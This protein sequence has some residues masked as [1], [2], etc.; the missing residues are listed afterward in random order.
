MTDW[1]KLKVVD[2]KAELKNRSLP[3]H[4]LKTELVARLEEAEQDTADGQDDA[5]SG[6]DVQ[7]TPDH[8]G[9]EDIEAPANGTGTA[10]TEPVEATELNTEETAEGNLQKENN[11]EE[12]TIVKPTEAA[13]DEA[14]SQEETSKS[15][16]TDEPV[17]PIPPEDAPT[18]D[19]ETEPQPTQ[20]AV[21]TSTE[22]QE[23]K[24][25]NALIEPTPTYSLEATPAAERQKRKRR[26]V[27]PPPTQG[28]IEHKRAR[29]ESDTEKG[30]PVVEPGSSNEEL[31]P[32]TEEQPE[33]MNIDQDPPAKDSRDSPVPLVESGSRPSPTAEMEDDMDYE[34]AVAPSVHTATP[35]LY[36]KNFMRPLRPD[37]VKTHLAG[38]AHSPRERTDESI[39]VDFFL[40]PIR[41]HAFVVFK[42]TTAASRVRTALHDSVW[43]NESNRKPL[44]VD[45]VPPEKV[46]GWIDTEMESGG[47]RGRSGSRWEVI[48]EDGPSGSVEAHLESG[49]ASFPRAG[50]PPSNRPPLGPSL[51][52]NDSIPLGPRGLRNQAIPTGPRPVRPG[53]GP[54]PRPP[55]SNPLGSS[56]R[57]Q[58]RPQI[59]YQP[60]TPDLAQTRIENMRSFYST[61]RHRDLGREI[62]RYSFESG[63]HFV[64]RGKE[65]FEGIRPPHR[66]RDRRGGGR[67]GRGGFRP[68]GDRYQPSRLD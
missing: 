39:I 47:P 13:N 19:R 67:R 55:P 52:S 30:A 38:L 24:D 35:A 59:H 1:A 12:E 40:D 63:V 41:T 44:W 17:H 66:E 58:A 61:D 42:S 28:A 43:P 6:Q 60:V 16:A 33:S 21:V 49:G 36:I 32:K 25:S 10:D 22:A 65:V 31:A 50:P 53:T 15:A 4:G 45:F 7:K 57:T 51:K 23:T 48:Y 68:R 20:L 5:E 46:L 64:D 8:D 9:A 18:N 27:T 11:Q 54:G 2:L 34:R 3:Q 26:S 14:P 29:L 56:K 37:E 62:N